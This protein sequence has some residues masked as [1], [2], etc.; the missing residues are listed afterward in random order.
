MGDPFANGVPVSRSPHLCKIPK[1]RGLP[2]F[3]DAARG[4]C[5]AGDQVQE[6]GFARTVPAHDSQPLP[7]EQ[8]RDERLALIIPE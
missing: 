7:C 5:D 3:T 1:D 4:R 8:R 2:D 6:G